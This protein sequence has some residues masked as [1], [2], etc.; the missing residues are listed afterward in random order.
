MKVLL[1]Y[2][3]LLSS[4]AAAE[5]FKITQSHPLAPEL[6]QSYALSDNEH[7]RELLTLAAS[8]SITPA[9]KATL[10]ANIKG[11]APSERS[12]TPNAA[13]TQPKKRT[14]PQH[15][16]NQGLIEQ[17]RSLLGPAEY[18]LGFLVRENPKL[19]LAFCEDV[20]NYAANPLFRAI[21]D[22]GGLFRQYCKMLE[23]G[24]VPYESF[25]PATVEP[26]QAAEPRRQ[27]VKEF[28]RT[29]N[30]MLEI[31]K[32]EELSKKREKPYR[33]I[34]VIGGQ[35]HRQEKQFLK[36]E[37]GD[38]VEVYD[39]FNKFR[40]TTVITREDL[41]VWVTESNTHSAFFEVRAHCRR[42][43]AAF[44]YFTQT[45][46]RLLAEKIKGLYKS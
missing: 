21:I 16:F 43:E 23:A 20:K 37:I 32:E 6:L 5:L 45:N 29:E 3:S 14:F 12:G 8:P 18:R 35:F 46:V 13:A 15:T 33:K 7:Q 11:T 34:Y 2:P 28:Q 36:T 26:H 19:I 42:V 41:V 38:L 30:C 10:R 39:Y 27:L 9:E 44:S 40:T 1:K 17:T 24:T 22:E 31:P 25:I 4:E